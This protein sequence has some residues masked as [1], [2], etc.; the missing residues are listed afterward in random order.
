MGFCCDRK[1]QGAMASYVLKRGRSNSRKLINLPERLDGRFQGLPRWGGSAGSSV[2][3]G[4]GGCEPF[5]K[6]SLKCE[7]VK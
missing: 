2:V 5:V 6:L 4:R 1:V 7:V 3:G